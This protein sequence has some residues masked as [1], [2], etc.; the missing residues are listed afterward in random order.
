[1]PS[2]D[3]DSRPHQ[4]PHQSCSSRKGKKIEKRILIPEDYE[5]D[6]DDDDVLVGETSFAEYPWMIEVLKKNRKTGS[7]EYKCGGVL[8]K[9][10]RYFLCN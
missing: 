7:F 6:E 4:R 3:F 1:M 9:F 2:T 10:L 5:G 8:S